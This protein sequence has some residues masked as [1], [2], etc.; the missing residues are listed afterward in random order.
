MQYNNEDC[1]KDSMLKVYK[2]IYQ[3][4]VNFLKFLQLIWQ[5]VN[6]RQLR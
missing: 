2:E 4:Y 5:F 6:E 1:N 3:T